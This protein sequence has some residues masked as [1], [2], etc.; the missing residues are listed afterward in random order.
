[1]SY[2]Y[3]VHLHT[4]ESSAC[5]QTPAREYIPYYIDHGYDGIVVTD[6][7]T[8]NPSYV[9]DRNAPWKQQVDEYCC[10]YEEALDE[11]IRRGFKV[12]FGIEQQ[13]ANDECLIYGP[14][15]Q[16]LLE[17]P[18]APHWTRRQWFDEINAIKGCIVLAHP[19]RVRD[20]VK[21]I[22][23]NTCVHA[24]EAFNSGNK[25]EADVY[26]LAYGQHFGYPLTAGTDMHR[27]SQGREL[28]GVVFEEPWENIFSYTLA[29][30][31]KKTFGVKTGEN[32]GSGIP[33][34]LERPYELLDLHEQ[35][36]NWD[37][38]ELFT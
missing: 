19:F 27:I 16:W 12:Y 32:R 31:A 11:G 4:A 15:K 37:V 18:D 14:N 5:G 1:M 20:Y 9:A 24:V 33:M 17:H 29:I 22:T 21:E 3:E 25:S 7:F 2:V 35:R 36:A 13:F 38:A 6:H 8:G 23:L 26:G 28:Y 34:P 30:R 10:G